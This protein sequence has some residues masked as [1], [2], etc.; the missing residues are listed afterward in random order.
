MK[1]IIEDSR[2]RGTGAPDAFRFSAID[3]DTYDGP[4]SPI[5]HGATPEEARAELLR[6]LQ[7]QHEAEHPELYADLYPD[8]D[9]VEDDLREF[10]RQHSWGRP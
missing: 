4:R 5:G 10:E 1:I 6:L 3:D 2:E 7:E 9:V 8:P